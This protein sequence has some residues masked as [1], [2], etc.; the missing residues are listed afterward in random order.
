MEYCDH[1]NPKSIFWCHQWAVSP[2]GNSDMSYAV[3]TALPPLP[4]QERDMPRGL[5]HSL[6]PGREDNVALIIMVTKYFLV[7]PVQ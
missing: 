5:H 6:P 7:N 4:K 2:A 1:E 3:S